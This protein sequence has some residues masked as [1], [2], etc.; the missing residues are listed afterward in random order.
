LF[1]YSKLN[2]DIGYRQGMH[3]ILAPVLWVVERDAIKDTDRDSTGDEA[4]LDLMSEMLHSRY[5]ENDAFSLFCVIMQTAKSFYEVG[6]HNQ[7]SSSQETSPIVIR[8]R[9]IHH[10]LLGVVDPQL[11][12]HLQAVEVLPQIFVM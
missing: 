4:G 1:V 10:D 12:N 7:T 6:D 11:A 2:P 8:S 9:R 5:I 3:E